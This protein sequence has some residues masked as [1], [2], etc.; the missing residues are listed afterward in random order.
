MSLRSKVFLASLHFSNKAADAPVVRNRTQSDRESCRVLAQ[1]LKRC[2]LM[3]AEV[4]KYMVY[5]RYVNEKGSKY[6][7]VDQKP[8][9]HYELHILVLVLNDSK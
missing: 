7:L 2:H 8:I 6:L 3:N 9:L 4:S 1:K 5:L